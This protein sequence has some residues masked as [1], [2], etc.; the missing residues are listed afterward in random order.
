MVFFWVQLGSTTWWELR[1]VR[2]GVPAHD[3]SSF[4]KPSIF[5]CLGERFSLVLC[6]LDER[7]KR[8]QLLYI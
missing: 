5:H 2:D 6:L 1:L 3:L 7:R 8:D 4:A